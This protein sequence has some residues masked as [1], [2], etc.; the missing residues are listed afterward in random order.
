MSIKP[1]DAYVVN[2]ARSKIHGCIQ[3][4]HWCWSYGHVRER[5]EEKRSTGRSS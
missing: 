1:I 4:A 2:L 3:G 5:N